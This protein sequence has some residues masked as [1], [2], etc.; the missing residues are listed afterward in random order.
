MTKKALLS[1]I[2]RLPPKQRIQLLSEAWDA[3]AAT[4]EDVPVAEWHIKEL[5][6]RLSEPEPRY[7][8]WEELRAPLR[9]SR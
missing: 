6:K 8:P 4:P 5:E 9:G 1:E 3:V 7:V 2:V